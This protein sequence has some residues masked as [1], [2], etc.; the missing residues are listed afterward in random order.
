MKKINWFVIIMT[1][2]LFA[3][4]GF[5]M[6]TQAPAVR[7]PAGP[8]AVVLILDGPLPQFDAPQ[9]FLGNMG[10]NQYDFLKTLRKAA[11]DLNVQEIVV[12][13]GAPEV[14]LGRASEIVAALKQVSAAGKPLTCHIDSVDNIGY[15]I[16]ASGCPK[17]LVSPAGGVEALGLSAEPLFVREFL[18]SLGIA[19]DM[20]HVGK[21]KDAMEPLVRDDMSPESKQAAEAMLR[22]LHRIFVDGIASGRKLSSDEVQRLIDTGPHDSSACL[23]AK[24]V[25]EI[26]PLSTYL[27]ILRD[28][29]PGEVEDRY[30]KTPPKQLSFGELLKMFGG[31]SEETNVKKTERIA[32][33]PV[34]GSIMGGKGNDFM[35]GAENVYDLELN[36]TLAKLARDDSVKA[37]VL[38]IDSPG[39]SALAS[40]NIW[41]AV[42]ALAAK[43]PVVASLGDVAA[44]GGYYIASAATEII[45]VPATLTGSIGVWGGKFVFSEAA[46]KLGVKTERIQT[47]SRAALSSPFSTF[48]QDE[49]AAIEKMML[50]TYNLFVDRIVEARGLNRDKV[51]E[52][53]EGRVWTGTQAEK[54]SLITRMGSL[55]DSISRAKELAKVPAG[56]PVEIEPAPKNIMDLLSEALGDTQASYAAKAIKSFPAG[57]A[58]LSM[59]SLLIDNRVL[60]FMPVI[61]N[62]K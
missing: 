62:T 49:R 34:I 11:Y 43:K 17:I 15:F 59:T 47:G 28:K 9:N 44:S 52:A 18:A 24:L 40:D 14:S 56:I 29:Y 32:L 20:L 35:S 48:N 4:C 8:F 6:E 41:H 39:G 37:V 19:A 27:D 36:E 16:A 21:Y 61:V 12:H 10:Q 25:D 22:E 38:R 50:S 31:K 60:A 55:D 23:V 7:T 33:V 30:G 54:H 26:S 53:A 57:Q 3:G 42:R 1:C 45:S 5:N 13:I 58:A 46:N 2:L 51:L